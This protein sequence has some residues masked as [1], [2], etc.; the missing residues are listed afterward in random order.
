MQPKTDFKCGRIGKRLEKL[1]EQYETMNQNANEMRYSQLKRENAEL[2]KSDDFPAV[3]EM[4]EQDNC[5]DLV[6]SENLSHDELI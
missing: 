4:Q 1:K 5:I 2:T 6:L 3:S